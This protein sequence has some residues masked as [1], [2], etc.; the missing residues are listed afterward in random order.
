VKRSAKALC[1]ACV[2]VCACAF[3]A[4]LDLTPIAYQVDAGAPPEDATIDAATDMDAGEVG[5]PPCIHCLT[6]PDDAASPGCA[7]EIAACTAN[8]ACT[9]IYECALMNQCF[10]QPS[11]REIVNCGIPCVAQSGIISSS[12]PALTLIYDIALCA[13]RSCNEPC[14]IGDAAIGGG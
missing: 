2:A 6:T 13:Q 9:I 1:A 14:H 11:F 3:A 7:Q 12:D 4:C 10:E 8:K 5:P